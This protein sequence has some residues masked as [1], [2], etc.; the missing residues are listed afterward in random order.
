[1]ATNPPDGTPIPPGMIVKYYIH[2]HGS[3]ESVLCGAAV[4]SVE[5][6]RPIRRKC[7]PKH[8]PTPIWHRVSF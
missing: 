2:G 1:M 7:K 6:V 5:D 3:D 4:V 8:V